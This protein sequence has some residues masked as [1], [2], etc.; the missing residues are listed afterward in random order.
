MTAWIIEG[1]PGKVIAINEFIGKKEI[2]NILIHNIWIIKPI[3]IFT[4]IFYV[5]VIRPS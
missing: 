4:G 1:I 3:K 5:K 2:S